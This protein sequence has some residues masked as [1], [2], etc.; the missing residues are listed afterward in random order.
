MNDTKFKLVNLFTFLQISSARC[1]LLKYYDRGK[2]QKLRVAH[3]QCQ[4]SPLTMDNGSVQ[5]QW[6]KNIRIFITLTTDQNGPA[7]TRVKLGSSV[8]RSKGLQ[9]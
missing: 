9:F 2:T 8:N 6:T 7:A 4:I 5:S 3:A 1:F